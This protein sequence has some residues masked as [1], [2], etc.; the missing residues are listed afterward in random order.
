MLMQE[1]LGES[2]RTLVVATTLDPQHAA[3]TIHTVRFGETCAQIQKKQQVYQ[4]ASIRDALKQIAHESLSLQT[5][6][7]LNER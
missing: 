1:T 7:K 3:E 2:A 4:L 6:M 5:D